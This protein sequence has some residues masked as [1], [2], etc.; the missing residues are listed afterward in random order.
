MLRIG[1]VLPARFQMMSF[2][3]LSAFELANVSGGEKLYDIHLLSEAGGP[4]P[5]SL[6]HDSRDPAL[7]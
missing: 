1:F 6:R 2:A 5:S 7:L 4:I 3:A